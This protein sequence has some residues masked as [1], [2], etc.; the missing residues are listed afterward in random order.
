MGKTKNQVIKERAMKG[1]ASFGIKTVRVG[2]KI[3]KT[4]S[5][6]TKKKQ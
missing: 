6:Q 2:K 1:F 3:I 4:K 5:C